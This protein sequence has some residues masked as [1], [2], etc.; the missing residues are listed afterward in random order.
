[1]PAR[2]K[3]P[4]AAVLQVSEHD[5]TEEQKYERSPEKQYDQANGPESH[6]QEA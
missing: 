6:P 4:G 3:V 5:E 1:M 2:G